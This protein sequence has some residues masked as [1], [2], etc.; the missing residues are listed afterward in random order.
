MPLKDLKLI[1]MTQHLLDTRLPKFVIHLTPSWGE[2][3]TEMDTREMQKY[4][5]EIVT[6]KR[7]IVFMVTRSRMPNSLNLVYSHSD[8]AYSDIGYDTVLSCT[9]LLVNRQNK[10]VIPV[11]AVYSR[12]LI[13][14]L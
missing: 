10:P 2:D 11:R 8:S 14:P 5:Y 7:N 13:W 1:R 6:G 3:G 12:K 9:S 4:I